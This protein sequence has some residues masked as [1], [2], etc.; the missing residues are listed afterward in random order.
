MTRRERVYENC[1]LE[2]RSHI[3]LGQV[4]VIWQVKGSERTLGEK[5]R[6]KQ[7]KPVADQGRKI[8]D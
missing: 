3:E 5:L 7:R 4:P 1:G 6:V 2:L 8:E